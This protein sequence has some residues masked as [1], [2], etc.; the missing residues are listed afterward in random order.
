MSTTQRAVAVTGLG[1]TT[2]LGFGVRDNWMALLAGRSGI[3]ALPEEAFA[4]PIALPVRIGAPVPREALQ[5]RIRDAVPR[6]V[7][8]TSPAVCHLWLLTALE[9]LAQAGLWPDLPAGVA[10]G[11]V[12]I[13]VGNGGGAVDF[14]EQEFANIYTAEQAVFRDVSRMAVPKY[15]T[16]SLSG[17]LSIATGLAGPSLT[18][19]TACSS[20]ATA[21]GLALDALRAGRIDVAVA[22]GA[23]L[24]LSATVLKGF[25]NLQALTAQPER[26]AA[27]SRPFDAGRRG[28][29]LG[30][31]AGCLVLER[32][33]TARA[34]GRPAL[35]RLAGS[36]ANSEAHHLLSP[37]PDG[38]GMATCISAAL[39]DAGVAPAAVAHVSATKGLLGHAIGGAGAIDAVLAVLSLTDG[40]MVPCVNVE[41][42]DAAC[43]VRLAREPAQSALRQPGAAVTVHAFA[44]GGQNAVLVFQAPSPTV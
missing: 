24:A 22:G 5:A 39:A 9:A 21:L 17:Q 15:M 41:Q 35:A 7:W 37:R 38:A 12:G 14:I 20:G 36:A 31:G 11:R 44:F 26:V 8:N 16:S 2:A 13:Y 42:P 18:V 25:S 34:R 19:N 28:F 43:P 4:T 23:E 33:Q 6:Q 1:L 10:P 27:A 40:Q 32:E 30:E 3:V 29:V